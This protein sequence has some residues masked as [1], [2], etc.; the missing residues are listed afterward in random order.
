MFTGLIQEIGKVGG[1]QRRGDS[2]QLRIVSELANGDLQLGESIAVNGACLTVIT[3]DSSSFTV[4]VS[5]E[6]LTCTTLGSFRPNM[7]VNLERAL[8][9]SDRLGGHL[10]SGHVDCIA[11]IRKR[12]Q[13]H[14][15]VRFEFALPEETLR[16]IVMK[17]SVA[18]DGISLTVNEVTQNSFSVMVIPHSL[19]MTTLQNCREGAEVN[20]ETDLIGRYVERLLQGKIAPQNSTGISLESLAKNGFM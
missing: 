14:N 2:A 13:E 9:L 3:W 4:D 20:I 18:I 15:A 16:Y 1:L 19:A 17:G 10:V 12:Y 8:R 7:P 11:K 5:P 6:T